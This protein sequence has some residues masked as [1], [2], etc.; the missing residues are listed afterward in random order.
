MEG[1]TSFRL[2]IKLKRLKEK[3]K[4][5]VKCYFAEVNASKVSILEELQ[6]L[7]L[8]EE[9]Y[10]LSLEEVDRRAQLNRAICQKSERMKPNGNK[11]QEFIG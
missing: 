7:D 8:E 3:I 9:S 2:S 1:K 4:E 5:W 10:L 6:R 11:D